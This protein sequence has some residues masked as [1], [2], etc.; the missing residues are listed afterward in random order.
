[1]QG[2]TRPGLFVVTG[3]LKNNKACKNWSVIVKF[4]YYK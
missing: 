4:V 3:N 2:K 1:M